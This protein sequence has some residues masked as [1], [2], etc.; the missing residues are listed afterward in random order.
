MISSGS[1]VINHLL[2]GG[3]EKEVVTTLY[4]PAG[5]GKSTLCLLALIEVAKQGKKVIYI[6]TEGGF[7]VERLKQLSKDHKEILKNVVFLKPTNFEEQK[8]S[9]EKLKGLINDSFGLII[10]DTIAMLY[11]LELGKT[12]NVYNVNRDLGRQ[13]S[14]LT[15]ITRKNKIPVLITN[16]VYSNFDERDKIVMVGGDILKYWSK[17]LI[18]IQ[19]TPNRKRRAVLKKHRHLAEGKEVMFEIKNSGLLSCSKNWLFR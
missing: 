10:V 11:R 18:E 12:E 8:K 3:Y 2:E 7:S 15:E 6:D 14:Y 5:S 4:G 1:A 9:F 13:I 16:Q 19:I 17:C